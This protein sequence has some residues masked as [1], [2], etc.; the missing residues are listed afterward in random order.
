MLC[1]ASA[2][3]I[4]GGRRRDDRFNGIFS[5]YEARTSYAPS[6]PRRLFGVRGLRITSNIMSLGSPL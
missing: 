5:A 4:A 2:E 3:S 1:G 6:R